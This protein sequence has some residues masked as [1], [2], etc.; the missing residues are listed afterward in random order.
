MPTF[1]S[2]DPQV[3]FGARLLNAQ[4]GS[5]R[6]V[7]SLQ[8]SA[9]DEH[10]HISFEAPQG[11]TLCSIQFQGGVEVTLPHHV[12]FLGSVSTGIK[13]TAVDLRNNSLI[14]E[15]DVSNVGAASFGIE[16]PWKSVSLAGGTIH[17]TDG[18]QYQVDFDRDGTA[19]DSFGYAH[20]KAVIHFA[21]RMTRC[22]P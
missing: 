16:T 12:P 17:H 9:H 10:A 11:T 2:F 18:N 4:C 20:R 3:P 8:Q 6:L 19:T 1:F 22:A 13:I 5:R 7:V 21:S 14:V 15:A